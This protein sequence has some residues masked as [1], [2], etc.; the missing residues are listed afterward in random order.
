M[1]RAPWVWRPRKRC[2]KPVSMVEWCRHPNAANLFALDEGARSR[3]YGT[4]RGEQACPQG[5]AT[6][7]HDFLIHFS[8]AP[9]TRRNMQSHLKDKG[10]RISFELENHI[11]NNLPSLF[12]CAVHHRVSKPRAILSTY[13]GR[14]A[15][16]VNGAGAQMQHLYLPMTLAQGT[17]IWQVGVPTAVCNKCS[18]F[19]HTFLIRSTYQRRRLEPF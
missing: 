10:M 19:S 7:L 4:H 13:Q 14:S 12:Y 16:P 5:F 15:E 1:S 18:W 8:Y 11:R 17:M 9:H 6:T 2:A 3:Y